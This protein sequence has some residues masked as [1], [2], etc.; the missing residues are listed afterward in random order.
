M[1]DNRNTSKNAGQKNASTAN[2]ISKDEGGC[3]QA[4][5]VSEIRPH[6]D[7]ISSC[8]CNMG[9]VDHLEGDAIKLTKNDSTDGKHHFIPKNWVDRVDNHVHLRKNA[10]ETRQEWQVDAASCGTCSG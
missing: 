1:S 2:P 7:V 6:M 8:G 9:K 4:K 3:G 10:E 5:Q